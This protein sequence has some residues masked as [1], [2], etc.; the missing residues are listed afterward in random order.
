MNL[1]DE[2]EGAVPTYGDALGADGLGADEA[3]DETGEALPPRRSLETSLFS[4]ETI[5]RYVA[6]FAA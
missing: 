3:L 5:E 4:I 6:R 1:L 2:W